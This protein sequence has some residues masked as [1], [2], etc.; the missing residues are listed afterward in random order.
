MSGTPSLDVLA[1]FVAVAEAASFSHAA[2]KLRMPKSSVSRRISALEAELGVQLVHRTTRQVSLSTAGTALYE[3]VA[4]HLAALSSSIG[5]LPESEEEPSG[6]LRVT[7][8]VD[9]GSTFLAGVVARF[10]ARFPKVSVHALVTNR[11]LDLVAE[12]IDVALRIS[13]GPLRDSSLVVRKASALA[14]HLYASPSYLARRGAP[15]T[16]ADLEE[17]DWIAFGGFPTSLRIFAP[18]DDRMVKPR[19]RLSSD[20]LFFVRE[21]ILGGAGIGFLPTYIADALA[22][23]GDLVVVLPKHEA[24]T[25][26]LYLV[27]PS[28]KHPPRKVCAFRDFVLDSLRARPLTPHA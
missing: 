8:P 25:G 9:L 23:S 6:T 26:T 11:V 14:G 17:H 1:V 12:R 24:T 3:R 10:L 15:R 18:G 22:L 27:F 7:A 16:T 2:K 28:S 5:E 19:G 20:D 21:A 4:P 13:T